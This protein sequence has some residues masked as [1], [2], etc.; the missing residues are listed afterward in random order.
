MSVIST[1]GDRPVKSRNR[2]LRI[3]VTMEAE[4]WIIRR[5]A[6]RFMQEAGDDCE[7][8]PAPARE[9]VPADVDVVLYADWPHYLLQPPALRRS[10]PTVLM[11]HHL[12][13]FAFRLRL[14]ALREDVMI[15][16]MSPRWV[17]FLRRW[18][19]PASK[20]LPLQYG[21][22]L[23]LFRPAGM[24]RS[25][26]KI[27]IGV[28]GR[29]YPDGRKGE[30]RLLNIARMIS[31]EQFTFQFMGDRWEQVEAE[32]QRLGFSVEV[33]RKCAEAE[34]PAIYQRMDCLLVCSR[35]EGGPL[36]ALEA[37]ACGVP[38]ISTDVGFLPELQKHM[39]FA[40]R[41]FEAEAS[42]VTHLQ[43]AKALKTEV[44]RRQA[45][46]KSKVEEYSWPRW[47]EKLKE[48]LTA[49][50]ALRERS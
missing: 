19:F 34:Q 40:V 24:P 38:V 44:D 11:V 17:R 10:I 36:P 46:V 20:L 12:D 35:K 30:D 49:T 27:C 26:Q 16:C 32:L 28:V 31:P 39:S 22:D 6:E 4:S 21:V 18:T 42:A 41:I 43:E 9:P 14:V 37:L 5:L 2:R 1:T 15:T 3:A 33:A 48:I 29:L 23:N 45:E 47:A 8:I 25:G 50:A 7:I 13:R